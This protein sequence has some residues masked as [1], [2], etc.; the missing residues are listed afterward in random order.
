M[1][2]YVRAGMEEP[3]ELRRAGRRP[4]IGVQ[5]NFDE[6]EGAKTRRDSAYRIIPPNVVNSAC[7]RV[8][9]HRK[10]PAYRLSPA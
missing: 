4:R 10:P 5:S 7:K 9:M 1:H 6:R 3:S 2:A 8:K